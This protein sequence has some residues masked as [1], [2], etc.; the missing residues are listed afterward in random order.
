MFK[1]QNIIISVIIT[2]AAVIFSCSTLPVVPGKL[3]KVGDVEFIGIK[4]GSFM[5]GSEEGESDE[6]PIKEVTVG[7][8]WISKYEITQGQYREVMGENPSRL[9]GD[10]LPVDNVS[11]NDAMKFCNEFGKKYGVT[12]RLPY[13]AEWEYA[14]RAGTTTRYY[15]GDR[16][17]G[18][19]AWYSK[20]SQESPHPVGQRKPNAW[21]LYDMIGNVWEWCMDW[22]LEDYYEFRPSVNPQG[23]EDVKHTRKV[24]RGGAWKFG[25]EYQRS[26]NRYFSEPSYKITGHGFRI[27]RVD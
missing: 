24:I 22:Y 16:M 18:A 11:W 21:G 1:P 3:I 8:F 6:V 20:N 15:W 2:A 13:E 10:D 27:V 12:V 5:M 14:C 4:G 25:E 9:K 26:A 7:D 23:P 17:N 19:Y